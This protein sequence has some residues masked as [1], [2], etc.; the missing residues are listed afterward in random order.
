MAH[1]VTP[2]TVKEQLQLIA[3]RVKGGADS[4]ASVWPPAR[5]GVYAVAKHPWE[6]NDEPPKSAG[7]RYV[8]KGDG[9]QNNQLRKRVGDLIIDICGYFDKDTGHHPFPYNF[10]DQFPGLDPM[11]LYISWAED[12]CASC[13]ENRL[14]DKFNDGALLQVKPS[15]CNFLILLGFLEPPVGFEPTTC[16][17][18][19][20][21]H[22]RSVSAKRP[23]AVDT[24]WTQEPFDCSLE[25]DF[26]ES[27]IDNLLIISDSQGR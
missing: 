25:L 3:E 1:W 14:Y 6:G 19:W 11:E 8:G 13:A 9:E 24:V 2:R 18:R 21:D 27:F 7:V 23:R 26:I 12:E 5:S 10:K 17:I 22:R 20:I 15:K 4:D 16:P